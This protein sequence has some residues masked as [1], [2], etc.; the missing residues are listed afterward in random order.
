M[1]ELEKKKKFSM[2]STDTERRKNLIVL[3]L[4]VI[5]LVVVILFFM[6]RSEHK[7]IMQSLNMEKNQIQEELNQ[8]VTHYDSLKTDNDTLNAALFVAQTKVKDLLLEV[9][10]IKKASYDQISKYQEEVGSLRKIMRNYIVQVD[11]LNRRNQQ[12]MEENQQVKQDYIAVESRNKALEQE[13]QQMEQRI[14]RAAMLE[15]LNLQVV[16]INRKGKE[17]NNSS[18]AEQ[19][20]ISFTLSKNVTA[21]RGAKDLYVRILRPDQILLVQSKS[22]L[23]RFEDL[24]IPY[25]AMRQVTYE[26]NQLP[27][28][29][30]WDNTGFDP[31]MT[32]DYTIDIFA[33]GN[34]IGTTTFSFKK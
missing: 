31:F 2:G 27:V 29:I 5:L 16:G 15:A 8:M 21:K 22:D 13:K 26:G 3:F 9:G 6:Q 34:N 17:V 24:R 1:A 28:N 10:Q 25:S 18:K 19:L 20:M 14:Q 12:L 7:A 11:S 30:Y 23:F 4:G 33:D 32:G